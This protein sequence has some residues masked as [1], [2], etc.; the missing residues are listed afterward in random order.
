MLL[1][2]QYITLY[3]IFQIFFEKLIYS[4]NFKW[5][6]HCVKFQPRPEIVEADR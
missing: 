2:C 6:V 3:Q 1:R 5:K 4:E